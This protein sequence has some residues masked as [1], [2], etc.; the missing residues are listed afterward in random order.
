MKAAQHVNVMYPVSHSLCISVEVSACYASLISLGFVV[1]TQPPLDVLKGRRLGRDNPVKVRL[2]CPI[3]NQ[4]NP[5]V[6]VTITDEN[7]AKTLWTTQ[8]LG[9]EIP[10]SGT[11]AGSRAVIATNGNRLAYTFG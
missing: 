1:E 3:P 10:S 8:S 4:Q 2:L 11:V 7:Q 9:N 5:M 6:N